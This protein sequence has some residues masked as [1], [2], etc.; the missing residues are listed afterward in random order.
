MMRLLRSGGFRSWRIDSEAHRG[1]FTI[2]AECGP[3]ELG[4]ASDRAA[5]DD[6]SKTC[7]RASEIAAFWTAAAAR[8]RDVEREHGA[9]KAAIYGSGVYGQFIASALQNP[10][11]VACYLDMSPHRQGKVINGIPVISPEAIADDVELIYVGLNPSHAR[12][13]IEQVSC[14]HAQQRKIVYL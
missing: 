7:I 3:A 11:A 1:A 5:T 12:Q 6:V 9:K 8:M 13:A 14:L 2:S 4:K 10:D